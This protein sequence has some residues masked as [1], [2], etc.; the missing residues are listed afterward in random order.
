MQPLGL[1]CKGSLLTLNLQELLNRRIRQDLTHL[2]FRTKCAQTKCCSY[3]EF[4]L[5]STQLILYI[6]L[7]YVST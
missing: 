5:P 4:L 2:P 3:L 1:K 7:K 6:L